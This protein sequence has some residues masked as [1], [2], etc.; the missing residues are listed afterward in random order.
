MERI[1]PCLFPSLSAA[2]DGL[3]QAFALAA[4]RRR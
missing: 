1:A 3:A 4:E 2:A